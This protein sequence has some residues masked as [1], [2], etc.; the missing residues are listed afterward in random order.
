MKWLL[1]LTITIGLTACVQSP[2]QNT[3]TIDN[4]PRVA[5]DEQLPAVPTFFRYSSNRRSLDDI[6][7][8]AE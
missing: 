4:R 7:A 5:F 8:G 6:P 2:T 3:T 1:L